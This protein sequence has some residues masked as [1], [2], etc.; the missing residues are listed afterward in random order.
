MIHR[1]L[2]A[3][4]VHSVFLKLLLVIIVA[5]F[6]INLAVSYFFVYLTRDYMQ[7]I[8]FRKQW[9]QYV[10]VSGAGHW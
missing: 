6:C 3:K 5:G 9:V 4:I 7:N 2:L 10:N 1:R 8:A